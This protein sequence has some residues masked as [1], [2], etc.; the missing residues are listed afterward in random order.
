MKPLHWNAP[1][2]IGR[3]SSKAKRSLANGDKPKVK[4]LPA[5]REVC[6]LTMKGIL[7]QIPAEPEVR[8]V[9]SSRRKPEKRFQ[10]MR[11]NSLPKQRAGT[12]V[13]EKEIRIAW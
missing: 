10:G 4:T 8:L 1:R 11:M 2:Q 7:L 13:F 6:N 5:R 12:A 3:C 9:N